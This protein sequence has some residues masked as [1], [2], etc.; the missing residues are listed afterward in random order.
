MSKENVYWWTEPVHNRQ[1]ATSKGRVEFTDVG[2]GPPILYFHGTGA[3]N[4]AAV[5]MERWLLDDGFR[6]IVPNRP[7]YYGTPLSCGR[8]PADCADLAAELLDQLGV[9]RVAVIGT[10]GGGL[11]APSFAARHPTRTNCLVL[12]CCMLHR[13]ASA[14]WMPQGLRIVHLFFRYHRVCMPIL[15]FGFRREVQKLRQ[16]PNSLVKHMSGAR[17]TELVD[18]EATQTL[19]PLLVDS[20][21]RCAE[22]PAG[23]E[24]D[25]VNA[26]GE[27]WLTPGSVRCPTL[28]LH[29]RADPLIPLAHVEWARQCIPQAEYCDLH[30]GGHLIWV[31]RDG[32]KMRELRTAFLRRHGDGAGE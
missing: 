11:A 12:Q 7:G 10:S 2:Q 1:V 13:L 9:D 32:P 15:R 26:V 20:E 6:L 30:A 14:R 21:L 19:V 5:F 24:N 29:D 28:I 18:D 4:D 16:R 23:V 3:G 17:S 31:G 27:N 8:T 22:Q 25:W